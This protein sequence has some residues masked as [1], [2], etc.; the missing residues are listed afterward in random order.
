MGKVKNFVTNSFN[1]VK[2]YW[3]KPKEGNHVSIKE[4]LYLSL[5]GMGVN[6]VQY[7]GA[8]LVVFAS[9]TF[10]ISQIYSIRIMDITIIATIGQILG[11]ALRPLFMMIT[12]NLGVLKPEF[13]K[14]LNIGSLIGG[15]IGIGF[16]F[17][18][19]N[20]VESFMPAFFQI[21]GITILTSIAAVYN[22]SY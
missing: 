7:I 3:N 8:H 4:F 14:W 20:A 19:I 17:V 10:L 1:T 16:M 2:K 11:F 22:C 5:G 15:A 18:P 12:D 6:G 13:K 9:G 21:I